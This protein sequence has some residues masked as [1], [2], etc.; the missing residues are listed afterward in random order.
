MSFIFPCLWIYVFPICCCIYVFPICR[1][2]YVFHIWFCIYVVYILSLYLYFHCNF[3]LLFG[4]VC[5]GF[6]VPLLLS[7][8]P[9]IKT[10]NFDNSNVLTMFYFHV[11]IINTYPVSKLLE[12]QISIPF[13]MFDSFFIRPATL[14]FQ[15]L[16]YIKVIQ[17]DHRSDACSHKT[18][19]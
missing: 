10:S 4:S 13:K 11:V 3:G 2:I 8:F 1:C 18:I 5:L 17:G 19:N 16:W 7:S 9:N 12:T 6:W 14:L 15:I